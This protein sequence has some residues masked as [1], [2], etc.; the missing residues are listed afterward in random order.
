MKYINAG[1]KSR[2]ELASRLIEGEVFY[3]QLES[4]L[5]FCERTKD[6]KFDDKK[7]DRCWSLF[8]TLNIKIDWKDSISKDKPVTCRME[9]VYTGLIQIVEVDCYSGGVFLSGTKNYN[10]KDYTVRPIEVKFLD[11][12]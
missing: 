6:F 5:W 11:E 8:K 12:N 1:I 4:K 9:N 10:E 2:S 3:S 7:L